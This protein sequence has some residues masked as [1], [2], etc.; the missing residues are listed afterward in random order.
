MRV[1]VSIGIVVV[2][3]ALAVFHFRFALP[4]SKASLLIAVHAAR[5]PVVAII[6]RAVRVDAAQDVGALHAVLTVSAVDVTAP[7][8]DAAVPIVDVAV[9]I[10]DP[11]V[12]SVCAIAVDDSTIDRHTRSRGCA[13]GRRGLMARRD[14]I[15]P[16]ATHSGCRTVAW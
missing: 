12:R 7:I 4:L 15:D 5:D 8:V 10:I 11:P 9:P 2:S 3:I 6:V 13:V 1:L 16:D 14:A